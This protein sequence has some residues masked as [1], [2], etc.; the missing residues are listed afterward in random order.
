MCSHARSVLWQSK[1]IK[2]VAVTPITIVATDAA[3]NKNNHQ[4]KQ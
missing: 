3:N 2:C 1:V 4:M